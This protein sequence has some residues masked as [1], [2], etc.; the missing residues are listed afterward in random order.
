M[1]ALVVSQLV[2]SIC[3]FVR[4]VLIARALGIEDFGIVSTFSV[5]IFFVEMSTDFAL[6]RFLIQYRYGSNRRP[7]SVVHGLMFMKGIIVSLA[8]YM[9]ASLMAAIFSLPDYVWGYELLAFVPLVKS[10]ANYDYA[11][12]QKG[13]DQRTYAAM[14]GIPQ[15]LSTLALIPMLYFTDSP[16]VIVAV[17]FINYAGF[18]LI[19]HIRARQK[20]RI[21]FEKNLLLR[22]L[23]FSAPLI[24]NGIFLFMILHG[25]RVIVGHFY[26]MGSLGMYTAVFSLFSVPIIFSQRLISTWF[27]PHL[28]RHLNSRNHEDYLAVAR[29]SSSVC[30]F[31]AVNAFVGFSL[32]GI[33]VVT[34][35]YG[36]E[37]TPETLLIIALGGSVA[38]R[39]YRMPSSVISMSQGMTKYEMLCS[40]SRTAGVLMAVYFASLGKPLYYI[41]ISAFTG[42]LIAATL[43]FFLLTRLPVPFVSLDV[44]KNSVFFV[45]LVFVVI[46]LEYYYP[47]GFWLSISKYLSLLSIILIYFFVFHRTDLLKV[48][49]GL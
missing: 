15:V 24:V 46:I 27:I 41:A 8:L 9:S 33:P 23:S 1:K 10:F 42:E 19:S 40:F 37:F 29:V 25:D 36:P 31:L 21:S 49:R 14:E 45:L 18:A 32:L 28:S 4:S 44:V 11:V 22:V 34:L 30:S 6:D 47:G 39:I 43:A 38:L 5:V 3:S 13:L 7:L 2:M 16:A 35:I 26:D 20:Y 48:A 12:Q 17:T